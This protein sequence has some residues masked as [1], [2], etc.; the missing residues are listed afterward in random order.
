MGAYYDVARRHWRFQFQIEGQRITGRGFPTRRD[1]LAAEHGA[2]QAARAPRLA[3]S[4]TFA[5]LGNAFLEMSAARRAPSRIRQVR[6]ILNR[7]CAHLAHV[8]VNDLVPGDFEEI[9]LG[10]HRSGRAP[11]T[12][13]MVR[14]VLHAVFAYGI[15][16]DCVQ[17]RNPISR[18]EPLP[19]PDR[20]IQPIPTEHLRRVIDASAGQR[21]HLIVFVAST[22]CRWVES[23]RLRWGDV[24]LDASPPHCLL[25]SAKGRAVGMRTR[26]HPLGRGAIAAIEAMRGAHPEWVFPSPRRGG[27]M[28]YTTCRCWLKEACHRAGV[29]EY[30]W[31]QIRHWA[32]T[33]GLE[34]VRSV[35]A[36]GSFLGHR[37]ARTTE[38]YLHAV[39]ADVLQ[40]ARY[41]DRIVGAGA[42]ANLGDLGLHLS[43]AYGKDDDL[44]HENDPSNTDTNG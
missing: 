21:R 17:G 20:R 23:A 38:V 25:H 26:V 35:R 9:I 24:R 6:S 18:I 13:N 8:P 31:H 32:A 1:A 22:G 16:L 34:A 11:R 39:P 42:G 30:S 12:V 41:I 27:P 36:V 40:V 29:P 5:K 43:D 14:Q 2:R 7:H 44:T 19:T 37:A 33:M 10:V 15:R 4:W 28:Q 3:V